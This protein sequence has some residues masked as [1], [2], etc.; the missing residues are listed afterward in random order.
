M[1]LLPIVYLS[2]SCFSCEPAC[3][4]RS[5]ASGTFLLNLLILVRVVWQRQGLWAQRQRQQQRTQEQQQQDPL[6]AVT[7]RA[8]QQHQQQGR[9]PAPAAPVPLAA[10]PP[11]RGPTLTSGGYFPPKQQQQQ[12]WTQQQQQQRTQQQQQQWH[13]AAVAPQTRGGELS[14]SSLEESAVHGQPA[15]PITGT[16]PN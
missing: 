1:L 7:E 4:P 2:P 8:W 10:W 12:Q 5:A 15:S 16:W 11:E 14:M 3:L 9:R 6:S 13:A